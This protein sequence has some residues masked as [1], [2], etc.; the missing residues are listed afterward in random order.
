[1][2]T[3]ITDF[4]FEFTGYGHYKVTYESPVTGYTWT[5]TINDMFLIDRT[6]NADDPKQCDLNLLKR[7]VKS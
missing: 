2:K 6:K 7:N 5:K 1:M 4:R 3:Q